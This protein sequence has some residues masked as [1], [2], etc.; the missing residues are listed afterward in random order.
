MEPDEHRYVQAKTLAQIATWDE[1]T[2]TGARLPR[3]LKEKNMGK[4][5][6][7]RNEE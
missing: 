2:P 6:R 1:E 5:R 7:S 4:A 3:K